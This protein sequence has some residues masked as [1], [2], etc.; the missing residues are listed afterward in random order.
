MVKLSI[1]FDKLKNLLDEYA[2]PHWEDK[3][4]KWGLRY[5]GGE[6]YIQEKVLKKA[7][8]LISKESL[9]VNSKNNI[10]NCLQKHQN[11]LSVYEGMQAKDFFNSAPEKELKEK[12]ANFVQAAADGM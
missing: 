10:I 1:N 8:P 3:S 12:L 9:L 2:K 6:E 11:L 4:K 7:A 5:G